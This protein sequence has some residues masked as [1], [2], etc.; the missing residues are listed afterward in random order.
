MTVF[1]PNQAARGAHVNVSGA[2]LTQSAKNRENAIRLIE[3]LANK[4]SQE[5]YA[6]VNGEYPVRQDVAENDT[7]TAWGKFKWDTLNLSRLGE[8]NPDA[9]RLMDRAGWK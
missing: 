7:L 3:F 4:R 2:A 8:L 9:V 5:W 1:W 6:E